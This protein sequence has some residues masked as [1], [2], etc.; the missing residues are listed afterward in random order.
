MFMKK[1]FLKVILAVILTVLT[2]TTSIYYGNITKKQI[3]N[4]LN[5]ISNFINESFSNNN[6][7]TIS[8]T[9]FERDENQNI[10][11]YSVDYNIDNIIKSISNFSK[12]KGTFSINNGKLKYQIG[13]FSEYSKNISNINYF[14]YQGFL[15]KQNTW[16][17]GKTLK[18]KIT[19]ITI[20]NS[21]KE[22][23]NESE[24]WDASQN[25]DGSVKCY[26]INNVLIISANGCDKIKLNKDA[27]ITFSD[28]SNDNFIN[29]KSIKG[30]E[31]LDTSNTVN[32]VAMFRNLKSL[33]SLDI[34]SFNTSNV[35]NVSYMF[36]GLKNLSGDLDLSNLDFSKVQNTV[37]TF[38][39]ASQ[40]SNKP[41]NLT[42]PKNLTII[43]DFTFNHLNNYSSEIFTIPKSVKTINFKHVFYNLGSKSNTFKDFLVEEGSLS[44]KTIDGILYDI[45][46]ERLIAV[47][48]GK[49]FLNQTFEIPEGVKL[50]NELSFSSTQNIKT[51]SLPN[52]YEIISDFS[53]T[54]YPNQTINSGN[55]LSVAIYHYAQVERFE[56]K[57]DN[58]K[59]KSIDGA[60]YSKD[61]LSLIAVPTKY[62]GKLIIPNGVTTI[63]L[64]A[65]N[66]R[67]AREYYDY[68]TKN[69]CHLNGLT[70][71]YIPK[72]LSSIDSVQLELLNFLI[73][74]RNVI[75]TIDANNPYFQLLN[76]K[77]TTK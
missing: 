7:F 10:T 59:Y 33:E 66:E 64:N 63:N 24:V 67:S 54:T 15:S 5:I 35:T 29:V 2:F 45:K 13:F 37:A 51:I 23:G 76:G 71:I 52:S 38:Q 50:L 75:I 55:S 14:N 49:T 68:N 34:S 44:F 25:N 41:L 61:G 26:I 43:D 36:D 77:I 20:T 22:T 72:S 62:N 60:I 53:P 47:P 40:N 16:Y 73:T 65:F 57:D 4:D 42:L 69:G 39:F 30:L 3:T 11:V 19:Q 1:N 12:L 18:S 21:Y 6:S 9:L 27:S 70:E 28:I 8:D 17:K 48:Q 56:V 46:G 74:E 58:P 32:M 31:F